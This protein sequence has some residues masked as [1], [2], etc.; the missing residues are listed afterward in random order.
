MT[1]S[2][3]SSRKAN[4]FRS[5]HRVIEVLCTKKEFDTNSPTNNHHTN[6]PHTSEIHN[7][8]DTAS[9]KQIIKC[10]LSRPNPV[11]TN[12]PPPPTKNCGRWRPTT[13]K[14]A[15]PRNQSINR[16]TQR[17]VLCRAP[18]LVY[19]HECLVGAPQHPSLCNVL[20][21]CTFVLLQATRRR[22]I[23]PCFFL[24]HPPASAKKRAGQPT[25]TM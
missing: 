14:R 10:C 16:D 9:H 18:L 25:A 12:S 8:N 7:T 11:P 19:S 5:L 22:S 4:A 3:L 15:H 21:L 23:W 1:W 24:Q 13:K 17:G 2:L 20:C 6:K